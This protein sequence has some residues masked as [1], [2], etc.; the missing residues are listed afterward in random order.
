MPKKY[1]EEN[2][3]KIRIH[4][5]LTKMETLLEHLSTNH[6]PHLERKVNWVLL[7]TATAAVSLIIDLIQKNI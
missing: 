2:E 1:T 4:E 7:T 6:L 3:D 5:R